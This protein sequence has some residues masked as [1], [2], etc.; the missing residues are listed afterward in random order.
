M[1]HDSNAPLFET[2]ENRQLLSVA[3]TPV[4]NSSGVRDY[5]VAQKI[6][7]EKFV[8]IPNGI[9]PALP[10]SGSRDELLSEL[11]LPAGVRLVGAVGRLWPQSST[12][13]V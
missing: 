7:A 4:V 6:P 8:V 2:L 9:P 3:P 11:G 12:T 10:K 5:Y 1:T 13:T